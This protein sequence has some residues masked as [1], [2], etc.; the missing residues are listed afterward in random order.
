MQSLPIST[1][2][3]ATAAVTAVALILFGVSQAKA[4]FLPVTDRG[5]LAGSD[6]LNWANLGPQ[7]TPVFGQFTITSN[8]GVPVTGTG[9]QPFF[10]RLDQ[11][12]PSGSGS[13]IFVGDFAPGDALLQTFT[14]DP[15]V[16]PSLTLNFGPLNVSAVGAQ[17][18]SAN[19]G[20]FVA[21]I[22]A[23]DGNG[24][25]VDTFTEAGVNTGS[26]DNSA[27]FIG[28]QTT[29]PSIQQV[30]FSLD[31]ADKGTPYNFA[32]NQVDFTATP[33]PS[34]LVL[35]GISIAV[36]TGYAGLRRRRP[37]VSAS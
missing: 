29:D 32:V 4:T 9:S 14:D 10:L 2:K 5:A 24:A 19:P 1:K 6:S 31:S 18:Q 35:L 8:G 34:S 7:A 30:R 11:A 16:T 26:A 20:A 3:C 36:L 33:E 28:F 17:T 13:G 27:I 15:T 21:R 22:D 12:D 25:V 37:A 23:L